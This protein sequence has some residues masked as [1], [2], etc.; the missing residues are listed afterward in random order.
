MSFQSQFATYENKCIMPSL[1]YPMR[2]PFMNSLPSSN[3]NNQNITLSNQRSTTGDDNKYYI[4]NFITNEHFSKQKF[5][6]SQQSNDFAL[7]WTCT[8]RENGTWYCPLRGD[9]Y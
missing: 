2:V 5:T 7:A 4:N 1:K 8:Q 9:K 3:M 6:N